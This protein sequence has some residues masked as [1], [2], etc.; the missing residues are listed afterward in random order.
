MATLQS[1]VVT[2]GL[3]IN[4][5]PVGSGKS[6]KYEEFTTSATFTPTADAISAGGIHQVFI[7]G[8]G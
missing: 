3:T 8:G 2:G 4:D 1:T 7:V 5:V 6:L